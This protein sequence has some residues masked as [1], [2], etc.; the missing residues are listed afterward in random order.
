MYL[1]LFIKNGKK[2]KIDC[3]RNEQLSISIIF[4]S[5]QQT[6][7]GTSRYGNNAG[8]SVGYAGQFKISNTMYV[9]CPK[10]RA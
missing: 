4:M 6:P 3:F 9:D 1:K 7:Q 5:K 10:D 2:Y 8:V